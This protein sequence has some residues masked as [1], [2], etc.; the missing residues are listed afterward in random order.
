MKG[1]WAIGAVAGVLTTVLIG[2]G[3][4]R[5]SPP[6]DVFLEPA[7]AAGPNAFMVLESP[8]LRMG[9]AERLILA[10]GIDIRIGIEPGLYGGSGSDHLC[11]PQLI[12][13]YLAENP[14]KASAWASASGIEVDEIE[15][16][17]ETLTPVRL[18]ADTWVTNHGYRDGKATPRQSIL[19][20]GS[21]VLVD[22]LG[23]PRVRCKC[24][25]PLKPPQVP[26]DLD[27]V[28]FVGEPWDGFDP[29]Q[30]L[31][32]EPGD[33]PVEWFTLVRLEDGRLVARPVGTVGDEDVPVDEDGNWIAELDLDLPPEAAVGDGPFTLP[34][35]T[36]GG[37]PIEYETEGPCRILGDELILSGEGGCVL[38]ASAEADEPWAA[39]DRRF[40]IDVG[41]LDQEIRVAPVGT[42]ALDGGPIDLGAVADSLLPVEY[43]ASGPCEIDGAELVPTGLGTC[44]VTIAQPG[45][46]RWEPA[47]PVVIT[48]EIVDGS[49]L[50]PVTIGLDLPSSIRLDAEPIPLAASTSP[51]RPVTY[52]VAGACA[53]VGGDTLI[54]ETVGDCE[55]VAVA[56]GDDRYRRAV[57][58]TT[59]TVLAGRQALGLDGVPRS[60]VLGAAVPLPATTSAGFDIDYAVIGNC[61][62]TA[63]G[64]EF[65]AA[66]SCTVVAS[67]EGDAETEPAT[68]R[69]EIAVVSPSASRQAQTITFDRPADLVVGGGGVRLSASS[70]SGLPVALT[71]TEGDCRLTGTTLSPGRAGR[72]TVVA[73]QAGDAEHEP[74]ESVTRTV[75][76]AKL[77]PTLTI[78]VTGGSA[79]EMTE[80]ETR[81]VTGAVSAGPPAA[82]TGTSGPCSRSGN[83]VTATGGS[84]GSC[85]V[86][87]AAP[88]DADHDPVSDTVSIRVK[89]HQTVS[90]SVRSTS[91]FVGGRVEAQASSS[92]GLPVS[93][94]AGPGGICALD[95]GT[96]VVGVGPGRCT[97]TA[98]AAG[99]GDYAPASRSLGIDV[100]AKRVPVVTIEAPSTMT[101]GQT[102]KV[103]ASSSEPGVSITIGVSG[104]ACESPAAGA[105]RAIARGTC[106]VTATHPATPESE[107]GS[108]RTTI[109]VTGRADGIG[110]D[111]IGSCNMTVGQ[112]VTVA[113]VTQ[114]GLIPSASVSG[115]CTI[116]GQESGAGRRDV[117]VRGDSAGTCGLAAST[118]GDATWEP[119]SNALSLTVSAR[120]ASVSFELGRAMVVGEKRGIDI[121]HDIP[122]DVVVAGISGSGACD[123][124]IDRTGRSGTVVATAEGV[125]TVTV[126]VSGRGYSSARSSDTA[127]VVRA[128]VTAIDRP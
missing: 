71:V 5:P 38:V 30:L 32:V 125:C 17:L 99:N 1:P 80:G 65:T 61:R 33:E 115:P 4:L 118:K 63:E 114:S 34:A 53:I 96:V 20:A 19:Q 112:D 26:S 62:L 24:G 70:S 126:T 40:E 95:A 122:P 120:S 86:T 76:V 15:S 75:V 59:L 91:V 109:S 67:A 8:D 51:R 100:V 16:Y 44:E 127:K 2:I 49:T 113:I 85:V 45:D 57:A 14:A 28:D 9:E 77:T 55:I 64:L 54:L 106:T 50:A 78:S 13:D 93:L 18:L 12:A 119:A 87:V 66:G 36:S 88:G 103:G 58:R 90:L 25:N 110:F 72:C 68:E 43:E 94:S 10:G 42:V 81:T 52:L 102:A 47:E 69:I 108:A 22:E 7:G 46:E 84:S 101:V 31:V 97:I 116:I 29:D 21:M 3:I 83:V 27:D 41:R 37:V 111:C 35:V 104:S 39:L 79:T 74:A 48:I 23:V 124:S 105:V 92:S 117:V 107:A 98:E 128:V 89:R 60:V 121:V 6:L 56:A 73:S 11:D 123:A 82:V